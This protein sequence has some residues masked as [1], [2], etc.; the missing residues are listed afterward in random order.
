MI[1]PEKAG[2]LWVNAVMLRRIEG[3]KDGEFVEI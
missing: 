2:V 3:S 1:F